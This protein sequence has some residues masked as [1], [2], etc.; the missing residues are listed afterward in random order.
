MGPGGKVGKLTR[1]WL[2]RQ[3]GVRAREPKIQHCQL[4]LLV[5]L[6]ADLILFIFFHL[7]STLFYLLSFYYPKKNKN[8]KYLQMKEPIVLCLEKEKK[9]EKL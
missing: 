1:R 2:P 9:R 3:E 4:A 6:L 5:I 8:L 7:F